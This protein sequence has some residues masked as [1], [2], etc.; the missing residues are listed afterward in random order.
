MDLHYYHSLD[1]VVTLCD[2]IYSAIGIYHWTLKNYIIWRRW[3]DLV[4][5]KQALYLDDCWLE[6]LIAYHRSM[7]KFHYLENIQHYWLDKL[8]Y[9]VILI[10]D[11]SSWVRVSSFWTNIMSDQ[12]IIELLSF[13]L[14][15]SLEWLDDYY[16]DILPGM[17]NVLISSFIHT[18]VASRDW[19]RV[20]WWSSYNITVMEQYYISLPT[21]CSDIADVYWS[22]KQWSL[23]TI[24]VPAYIY[25]NI[26]GCYHFSSIYVHRPDVHRSTKSSA[27][28]LDALRFEQ[29]L[30]CCRLSCIALPA[31]LIVRL[32]FFSLQRFLMLPSTDAGQTLPLIYIHSWFML[33][34]LLILAHSTVQW[35]RLRSHCTVAM[36][37][38]LQQYFDF[39]STA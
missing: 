12:V 34:V 14:R 17:N 27:V 31:M 18:E 13:T 7:H 2:W 29:C 8:L 38:D 35:L 30:F 25:S 20:A 6:L 4:W 37:A 19:T 16:S 11:I 1:L 23:S 9:L 33:I 3:L 24:I 39:R 28:G 10:D 21:M 15:C 26:P 32:R 22:H 36:L 5:D